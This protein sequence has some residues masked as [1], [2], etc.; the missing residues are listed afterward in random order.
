[1]ISLRRKTGQGVTIMKRQ[2]E[3]NKGEGNSKETWRGFDKLGLFVIKTNVIKKER[4]YFSFIVSV[5]LFLTN[6]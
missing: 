6:C 3:T 1:M 2:E 4:V 5:L